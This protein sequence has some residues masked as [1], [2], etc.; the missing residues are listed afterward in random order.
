MATSE[1]AAGGRL[2]CTFRLAGRLFGVD[3]RDVKEVNPET[4]LTR[5]PHAPPEALGYVNLRGQIHLV[6]DARRLLDLPPG[7]VTPDARLVLFK[8]AIGD[9]FGI[10]VDRIGDVVSL[11]EDR[12]EAWRAAGDGPKAEGLRGGDLIDAVGKLDGELLVVL[13][14]RRFLKVVEAA[15]AN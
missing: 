8:P 10:L 3:V 9:A 14:P 5:V 13:Q 6:L 2:F 12:L 1:G 4:T 15:L 7:E 11:A